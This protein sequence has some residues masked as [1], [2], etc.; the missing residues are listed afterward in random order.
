[1]Y[2]CSECG[3]LVGAEDE[4]VCDEPSRPCRSCQIF[5][6]QRRVRYDDDY[7]GDEG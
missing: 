4:T 3:L 6:A 2:R 7:D 1:M 5:V